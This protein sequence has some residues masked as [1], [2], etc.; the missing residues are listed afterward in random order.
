MKKNWGIISVAM[1]VLQHSA[2]AEGAASRKYAD[3]QREMDALVRTQPES[4]KKFTLGVSDDGR[5]IEGISIG[6]GAVQNLLVS[7]HHGNEYGSAEVALATA[8]SLVANPI[9]GETIH[10]I[11]VLNLSGY[12]AH[13]R[14]ERAK[15]QSWDPNRNYP[16]PCGTEG[17]FTLKSTR[18][19]ASFIEQ[20]EIVASAT[21]HTYYPA[22]V[23]PWGL[24]THDLGTAYDAIF[25]ALTH[26][27]A[28]ESGYQTGNSTA[29]IY[30]ADGTFEDYAFWKHGI[31]S[32]LFEL[33]HSHNPS[34]ADVEEMNRVNVPGIRRL[35]E[36]APTQRAERHAF[37][38]RCDSKLRHMDRHD[39]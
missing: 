24:S 39:E 30:P 38:G 11:P 5:A 16:G 29:V 6:S 22:V 15:G 37:L 8:R 36:Q 33:G 1:F 17:P 13:N 2:H 18:A 4:V 14:R 31:W 35:F 21:L 12:D 7:T 3:I 10:V 23:Y 9:P 28:L 19:L 32:L 20:K 25:Q 27:A 26:A 34:D